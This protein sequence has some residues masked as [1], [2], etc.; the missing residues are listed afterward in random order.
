MWILERRI[1]RGPR[2]VETGRRFRA[3][4]REVGDD[5][6]RLRVPFV[7]FRLGEVGCSF[8]SQRGMG[9]NVVLIPDDGFRDEILQFILG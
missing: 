5:A 4:D 6:E 7:P 3:A 1:K 2:E 9:G 8:L